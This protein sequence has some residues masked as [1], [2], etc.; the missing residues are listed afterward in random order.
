MLLRRATNIQQ[1]AKTDVN[2]NEYLQGHELWKKAHQE[3]LAAA[4][5]REVARCGLVLR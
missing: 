2:N 1:A 3:E 5:K 4:G